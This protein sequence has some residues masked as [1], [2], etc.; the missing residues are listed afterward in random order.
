MTA[1]LLMMSRVSDACDL[2]FVN[3]Y[4]IRAAVRVRGLVVGYDLIDLQTVSEATPGASNLGTG[5]KS[6]LGI[7]IAIR[8]VVSGRMSTAETTVVPLSYGPDCRT[9]LTSTLRAS[10]EQKY[11]IGA[12][13]VVRG[14]AAGSPTSAIVAEARRH[15]FIEAVAADVL[16]TPEGDLDFR[17]ADRTV[18][19][20]AAQFE[21]ERVLLTLASSRATV[22]A[23]L[24]NLA[25]SSGWQS[26]D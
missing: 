10:I 19:F 15:D 5:D 9:Y 3:D 18:S 6:L 7:R 17:R 24:W 25:F 14:T 11:P 2:V 21:F 22:Y 12:H 13:V 20:Y 16:R 23:R 26:S 1:A 4:P 8:E